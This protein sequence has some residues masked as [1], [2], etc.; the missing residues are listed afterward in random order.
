MTRRESRPRGPR[1]TAVFGALLAIGLV[2]C[3]QRREAPPVTEI[4]PDTRARLGLTADARDPTDR[5]K[6]AGYGMWRA[7]PET[8]GTQDPLSPERR[9]F[10]GPDL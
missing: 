3:G 10:G 2:S 5:D 1:S 6:D 4:D 8:T 9:K 7:K